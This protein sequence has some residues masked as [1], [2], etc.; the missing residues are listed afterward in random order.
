MIVNFDVNK[1]KILS[2]AKSLVADA[3]PGV[4]ASSRVILIF[5]DAFRS[6]ARCTV[7]KENLHGCPGK[8]D[9]LIPREEDST[10][11]Q[12]ALKDT[13]LLVLRAGDEEIPS[14][15]HVRV[16]DSHSLKNIWPQRED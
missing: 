11:C 5:L 12:G 3:F 9:V 13:K 1:E 4:W 8:P 2:M 14:T 10:C 16:K 7:A 6:M 15:K